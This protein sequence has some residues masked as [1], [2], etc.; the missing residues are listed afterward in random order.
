MLSRRRSAA[1]AQPDASGLADRTRDVR[2][3]PG[4]EQEHKGGITRAAR[5]SPTRDATVPMVTAAR[6]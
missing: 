1:F 2:H 4:T 5:M 6:W 3:R